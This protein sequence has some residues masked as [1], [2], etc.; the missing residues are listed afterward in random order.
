[1]DELELKFRLDATAAARWRADLVARHAQRT[2]LKATYFDTDDARL[3][4]ARVAL[5]LRQEGE[6]WVQTLKA[7]GDSP[8][9]RLEHNAVVAATGRA[10]PAL[11][12]SR[13]AD[14]PALARLR[15]A[16]ADLPD[17]AL[18]ERYSTDIQRLSLALETSDG[19]RIEAAL[20]VG[21]IRAA[22]RRCEVAELELEHL[23]GP[24]DALFRLADEAL[25]AGGLWLSTISKAEQGELLYRHQSAAAVRAQA[26]KLPR[27][28]NGPT[29]MRALLANTLAQVLPNASAVAEG[30][31]QAEQVHQL[32]VGL[33]RLRTVLDELTALCPP[34]R[35]EWGAALAHTFT[36]LGLRRDQEALAEAVRPL[37]DGALAPKSTWAAPPT[38]DPATE[39]RQAGFQR[40]LIQLLALLH[41]PDE[42]YAALDH[43]AVQR[44][45]A[46][47]LGRLHTQACRVG[48]DFDELPLLPQ[49][50]ARKRLKRLRYLSEFALALW[51][52]K[53][54]RRYVKALAPVQEAL[55]WHVDCALAAGHFRHEAQADPAAWFAAGFL[56]AHR[57]VTAREAQRALRSLRE[58]KPFWGS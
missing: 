26:L 25:Q 51:P 56:Q 34:A 32:R 43:R 49:H 4:Q 3:A 37:L 1:M 12:L 24:R 14:H 53:A 44:L 54:A 8:I 47:R 17:A 36:R 38:P 21:E 18:T 42:A 35:T 28:A 57:T 50:R 55:G 10:R 52:G 46:Q 58:L 41:A 45:F 2:P 16:L 20:D 33:R 22:G 29:V 13:H 19:A 31:E 7:E 48:A 11:D 5:R 27:G 39:V 15:A 6:R 40:T 30:G 9:H 23:D